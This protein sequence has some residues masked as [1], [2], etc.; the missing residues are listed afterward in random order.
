MEQYKTLEKI[1]RKLGDI[2]QVSAA[3]HWDT[4]VVMP[5]GGARARGYQLAT[6]TSIHH[7]ILADEGVGD[8]I[9]EAKA[10]EK[11]LDDWQ[12]ANLF[13]MGKTY[14]HTA[15]VPRKLAEELT[16]E[17]LACEI[18]WREARRDNN[19]RILK[20]SLEK[21]V[22][23][24]RE[25]AKIKSEA[26]GCLPYDALLDQYDRGRKSEQLDKIFGNLQEFLPGF[27]QAVVEKQAKEKPVEKLQGPFPVEKQKI[28][29]RKMLEVLGFDFAKGR[30][31]ESH[32]PFCGGYQ[33]DVRITTRYDEANF[34]SAIM[35]VQHECGHALYEAGLPGKWQGQ[36]VGEAR[37]MSVHE[38]QSLLVEM[39]VCRSLP[40]L[41]YAAPVYKEAFGGEGDAWSAENLYKICTRVEPSLIRVDADEV[42]YPAHIL[43]RYYIEKYLVSGD[44]EVA[45][46][47][48]A[49]S[50]GM[51]KFL[52][53]KPDSDKNGCMQDIHWMDG[54]FGY[55]PTY[56]LGAIY[57][58]QTFKALKAANPSVETEISKGDFKG[59]FGW[60][61]KNIHENGCRYSADELIKKATGS[62]LD[63]EVYKE[64][65]KARY[66]DS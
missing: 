47:P 29:A 7:A 51:E 44:M 41:Q 31:D 57:A 26:F 39:Q 43:M 36:P 56:T 6:L 55:F 30:F 40:F 58:A 4:A 17:G 38:S 59:L 20:P 3:L 21:V 64:H 53:V 48:D 46:L 33:G 12:K 10:D 63:V 16:R 8:L 45:D 61:K 9:A 27:I 24:V 23:L 54:T 65:L 52:G 2:N 42:T 19:F 28:L 62:E 60:L 14:S 1:F 5:P 37:G 13:E 50:Q 11:S 49:W 22:K 35:G 32:H 34:I 15:A 18:Q 66:L 25:I